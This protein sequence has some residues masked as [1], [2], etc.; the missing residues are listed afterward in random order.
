[1]AVTCF[2]G[3]KSPRYRHAGYEFGDGDEMNTAH[4]FINVVQFISI[5]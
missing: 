2:S 1:M 5:E 4:V 3:L